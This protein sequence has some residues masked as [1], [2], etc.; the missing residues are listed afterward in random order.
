M[1]DI[2]RPE[3]PTLV[4][5]TRQDY[6]LAVRR[7]RDLSEV[8]PNTSQYLELVALRAALAVWKNQHQNQLPC[9]ASGAGIGE[10]P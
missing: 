8:G 1:D 2:L 10:G 4:I 9:P 5:T 3:A 6:E 7:V